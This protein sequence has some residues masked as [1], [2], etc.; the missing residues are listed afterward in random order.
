MI[1]ATLAFLARIPA[2][3]KLALGVALV[4]IVMF[5]AYKYQQARADRAEAQLRPARVTIEA[6][7]KV[8]TETAVIQAD[9][10]EKQ[11]AVDEIEGSE[12][13]LPD[14]YGARIECVRRGGRDC[15]S[16]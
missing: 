8:N 7:D 10:A 16:R 9:T 6:L 15:N 2:R 12:T 1:A 4:L 5:A 14:G 13:R 11:R 3:V